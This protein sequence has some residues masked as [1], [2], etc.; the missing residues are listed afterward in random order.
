MDYSQHGKVNTRP[1]KCW[2]K[3]FMHS[4]TSRVQPR[5]DKW[6]HLALYNGCNYLSIDG[7]K[8]IDVSKRGPSRKQFRCA[9]FV[10]WIMFSEFMM[11]SS[12]G[13]FFCVTGHLCG[14]FNGP[15]WI[16]RTK[17][18]DA[19][20]WCFLWSWGWWFGTLSHPLWR[21]CNVVF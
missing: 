18:S 21:H 7:I 2:M 20:L 10:C 11:T 9:A 14:E 13:I 1:E 15:R 16:P 4:Q 5:M 3:L 12:N 6:F 19:E 8:L 17:A